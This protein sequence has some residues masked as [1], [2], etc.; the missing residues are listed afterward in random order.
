MIR[1]PGMERDSYISHNV[2]LPH[3][4]PPYSCSLTSYREHCAHTG[5]YCDRKDRSIQNPIHSRLFY[6]HNNIMST[7]YQRLYHCFDV[8]FP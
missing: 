3:L 2:S 7:F 6:S 8:R 4:L 5:A 1:E